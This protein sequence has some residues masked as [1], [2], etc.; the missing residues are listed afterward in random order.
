[1]WLRVKKRVKFFGT[2]RNLGLAH[3]ILS[4]QMLIFVHR[5]H[6]NPCSHPYLNTTATAMAQSIT[7]KIPALH[8]EISV[9]TGLF[10]NNEFVSSVDS[11]ET[12][13]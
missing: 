9:P 2:Q 12:L 8:K 10:I 6:N 3:L 11:C 1:M 13:E 5:R 7:V 4:I